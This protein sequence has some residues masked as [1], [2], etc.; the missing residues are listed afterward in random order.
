[1][2]NILDSI[3]TCQYLVTPDS[4]NTIAN[5]AGEIQQVKSAETPRADI[6]VTPVQ[7]GSSR[8]K[9]HTAVE[10]LPGSSNNQSTTISEI[11][12]LVGV[13]R[14]G[15]STDSRKIYGALETINTSIQ[16][17]GVLTEG[18]VIFRKTDASGPADGVFNDIG[19]RVENAP[20]NTTVAGENAG[21]VAVATGSIGK[22]IILSY[23]GPYL[24]VDLSRS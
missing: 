11:A 8:R 19:K 17:C 4:D 1:M 15:G 5:A 10:I 21:T 7:E 18:V 6:D 14:E 2:P 12:P 3:Q 20:V 16:R 24:L 22:G 9:V 13:I 23:D